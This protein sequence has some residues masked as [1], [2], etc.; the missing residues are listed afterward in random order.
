MKKT[1]ALKIVVM[2][3]L[4]LIIPLFK[5]VS[6]GLLSI[7]STVLIYAIYGMGYD[8]LYGYTNQTSYGHSLFLGLGAYG[9]LLSVRNMNADFFIA[10]LI[11]VA[12]VTVA[13]IAIGLFAVRMEESYFVITT[14]IL[15]WIGYYL[16]MNMVNITGGDDGLSMTL[17]PISLGFISFSLYDPLIGYYVFLSFF[18]V[19]L[20]VLERIVSSP[21]GKVFIAVR[22]NP[23][24]VEFLGYNLFYC[25]FIA[26]VISAVI[27]G[28]AG[29]LLAVRFRYA[30]ATYFNITYSALP[31]IWTVLGGA[32]TLWGALIGA[33]IY[34]LFVYFVSA[35]WANYLILFGALLITVMKFSPKGILGIIKKKISWG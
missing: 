30:S 33:A 20:V 24:R 12:V 23:N 15:V 11:G 14:I 10:L 7:M 16:A 34:L 35:W 21:L 9:F 5:D 8:I 27:A 6:S 2:V 18:A 13:A 4:A 17:P 19:V 26:F 25:K 29:S 22:T 32:G 3:I 31:I 28:L 1:T